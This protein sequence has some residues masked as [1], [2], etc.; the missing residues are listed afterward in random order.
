MPTFAANGVDLH[1]QTMGLCG[2]T[3]AMLHGLVI[4]NLAT[5]YFTAGSQLAADHRVLLYDLRGHGRSERTATGY[6]LS[7]MTEDL[8]AVLGQADASR[9]VSLVGHSYGGLVALRYTLAHPERVARLALVD[10]PRSASSIATS[11]QP[12]GV[13]GEDLMSGLPD[14]MRAAVSRGSRRAKNLVDSLRFLLGQSTLLADLAAEAD[15]TPEDLAQIRCPVLCLYGAKSFFLP[16]CRF[17]VDGLTEVQS[18]VLPGQHHLPLES[19]AQVSE[20]LQ[21]FLHG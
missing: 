17:Y 8:D 4:G 3:V 21:E 6:D 14:F 1:V 18:A 2:D 5:W 20:R 13:T 11:L 15:I 9:V 10:V 12:K 16:D 7:T 19:P